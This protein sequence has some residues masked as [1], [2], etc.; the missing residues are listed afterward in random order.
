MDDSAEILIYCNYEQPGGVERVSL[1]LRDFLDR[2]DHD[3][4]LVSLFGDPIFGERSTALENRSFAGRTIVFSRK[5]DLREIGARARG[6]RLV[7]WRHVPVWQ[8]GMKRLIENAFI[9]Y[10]S[11]RGKIACVCDD[12]AAEICAL[13]FVNVSNVF[14]CYSP[15]SEGLPETVPIRMPASDRPFRLAYF[16]RRG[17]QKRLEDVLNQVLEARERGFEL[18]VFVY[19]YEETPVSEPIEG[20]HFVGPVDDPLAALSAADAV[21]LISDYEG[22]PTIMVEAALTGTPIIA[23]EFRTGLEDFDRLVGPVT[24]MDPQDP[25]AL[26]QA[27]GALEPGEYRFDALTDR[28]LARDWLWVLGGQ[29]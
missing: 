23:N 2:L 17:S 8:R 24:R 3:A 6:A 22:F 7:Y 12:L 29:G 19:G 11:R 13:P 25:G 15:V 21:V 14:A 9:A 27:L 10:M 16:G 5:A 26:A 28:V 1:R 4:E 20:V 18:D